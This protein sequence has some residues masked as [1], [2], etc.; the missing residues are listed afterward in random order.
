MKTIRS[1]TALL[2]TAMLIFACA[3]QALAAET[4]QVQVKAEYKYDEARKMLDLVNK[5]RTNKKTA[6]YLD[7]DNKTKVKVKNLGKL[8]YDYNLERTAMQRAVEIAAYFSHTRPNASQWSSAFPNGYNS[9]GENICYGYGSAKAAFDAFAEEDKN[10]NGQGHRRNML[11]SEF[12]KVGFGCVKVGNMVYWAQAFGAGGSKGVDSNRYKSN[13]V[14]A[15]SDLLV[16]NA[17]NVMAEEEMLTVNVGESVSLPN[18]IIQSNT[19]AKLVLNDCKWKAK[20]SGVSVKGKKVTGKS[21]GMSTVETSIG[22]KSIQ[23]PVS[24]VNDGKDHD[25]APTIIED[26]DPPL[27]WGDEFMVVLEDDEC[28]EIE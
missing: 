26:Y 4:V 24:V 6:W 18:A 14:D 23:L 7:K 15:S 28:F 12:T 3:S 9:K 2:L 21:T 10:Y 5:F 27:G 19:G 1:L 16:K 13:T 20:D 25:E 8:E 17:R 22:N 11:R